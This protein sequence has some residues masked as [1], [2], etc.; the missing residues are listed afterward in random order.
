MD[1]KFWQNV[2]ED[3]VNLGMS[4]L[5]GCVMCL[6]FWVFLAFLPSLVE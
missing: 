1:K 4:L 3:L 6:F 5:W 2:V